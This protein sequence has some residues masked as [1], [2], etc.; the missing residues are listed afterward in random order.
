M[1]ETIYKIL[2]ATIEDF[3]GLWEVCW[4]LNSI[5]PK[6]K[7]KDNQFI[8]IKI[9]QY[10]L[11][12]ELVS[13]YLSI[14][15]N[16]ELNE[17]SLEEATQLLKDEKYWDAPAINE[18]CIKIGNTKKGEKYYNKNLINDITLQEILRS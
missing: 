12:Q 16:D 6:N 5:Y 1:K 9:I 8:A 11:E 13:L 18:V 17:V 14:W 7:K 2:W 3:V 10:F 15:G 4:E